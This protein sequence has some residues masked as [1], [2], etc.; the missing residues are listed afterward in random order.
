MSDLPSNRFNPHQKRESSRNTFDRLRDEADA[1]DA[2][3]ASAKEAASD[4]ALLDLQA[5]QKSDNMN[6]SSLAESL[7]VPV[8]KVPK[9]DKNVDMAALLAAT[10]KQMAEKKK[11]LLAA[12]EAEAARAR[13]AE[14]ATAPTPS[15]VAV[16]GQ[17]SQ[18]NDAMDIEQSVLPPPIPSAMPDEEEI[19]EPEGTPFPY[20]DIPVGKVPKE[21][22]AILVP[23]HEDP[24]IFG[25][26][27]T[28]PIGYMIDVNINAGRHG[29]PFLT[30]SIHVATQD[31]GKVSSKETDSYETRTLKWHPAEW[32][33]AGDSMINIMQRDPFTSWHQETHPQS[34]ANSRIQALNRLSD[35]DKAKWWVIGCD[36]NCPVVTD[37]KTW[38]TANKMPQRLR[39]DLA[40][41]QE[42]SLVYIFVSPSAGRWRR[43]VDHTDLL[44]RRVQQDLGI[45]SQYKN[46][47]SGDDL[48]LD[49]LDAPTI[50]QVGDGMHILPGNR[51]NKFAKKTE[52]EHLR[53]F[54]IF[55]ALGPVRDAQAIRSRHLSV[56]TQP[57]ECYVRALPKFSS[58]FKVGKDKQHKDIQEMDDWVLM[59]ARCTDGESIKTIPEPGTKLALEWDTSSKVYNQKHVP[60]IAFVRPPLPLR[61]M[62]VQRHNSEFTTTRTD[63]CMLIR[64]GNLFMPGLSDELKCV[65]VGLRKCRITLDF[66][67]LPFQRE[68][69]AV[70]KF[71]NESSTHAPTLA[72][73][74]LLMNGWR[75]PKAQPVDLRQLDKNPD[76][77][78]I[79][80]EEYNKARQ[81]LNNPSQLAVIEKLTNIESSTLAVQDPAGTG[82]TSVT[83]EI[84][85]VLALLGHKVA[86]LA[87]TDNAVDNLLL[88][89]RKKELSRSEAKVRSMSVRVETTV[90]E[91][92][93]VMQEAFVDDSD[94]DQ[95]LPAPQRAKIE[96]DI[97][98]SMA[99]AALLDESLATKD[100]IKKIMAW[101]KLQIEFS[102]Q[103]DAHRELY[104]Q[105]R[106]AA[107][108]NQ[109]QSHVPFDMKLGGRIRA[110]VIRERL[111]GEAEEAEERRLNP[112]KEDIKSAAERYPV[113]AQYWKFY[114]EFLE[115]GTKM[116]W[117]SQ[118]KFWNLRRQMERRPIVIIV[119]EGGQASVAALCVPLAKFTGWKALILV[120]DPTQ[121]RPTIIAREENEVYENSIMSPLEML[122][123]RRSNLHF[124]DMQYRM[125]PAISY[126]PSVQFYGGRLKNHPLAEVDNNHR[127]LMRASSA[128]YGLPE[129]EYFWMDVRNGE[130]RAEPGGHSL[131][132]HAN[133]DV[134]NDLINKF[135]AARIPANDI[136]ILTMYK[137][138]LRLLLKR[139]PR[140]NKGNLR[141]HEIS[142]IDAFQGRESRII[143][144][145]FVQTKKVIAFVQDQTDQGILPED[146]P[147]NIYGRASS[148]VRD[149]H[150]VNTALTRAQDGLIVVGQ[151]SFF[152]G[153]LTGRTE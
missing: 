83:S 57:L 130:G 51:F 97:R 52:F 88:E 115:Q 109:K 21:R 48:L 45:L 3:E 99:Y 39:S 150:R 91:K 31:T 136:V 86:V 142:T 66:S 44:I 8:P 100:D 26:L 127:H 30:L 55:S 104:E 41:L 138:Q 94:Q 70:H 50:K 62:V 117:A 10:V 105:L 14:A 29:F 12:R 23:L 47:V 42:G 132:N 5:A 36:L 101:E 19:D 90:I 145:D 59:Y 33:S 56:Q 68:L 2:R 140:D 4:Q 11:V 7:S 146:H 80:N 137:A 24:E 27:T 128:S 103:L 133:A 144:L 111:A 120:G 61:G 108:I 110:I 98:V 16:P 49:V 6:M 17:L 118:N 151:Y 119:D 82:K 54:Q 20:G 113:S 112:I 93:M 147:I 135:E 89:Y 114:Q 92:S 60:G 96:Q 71:C 141:F 153:D 22:C 149:S 34:R 78:R 15:G 58:D 65:N 13:A 37:F 121:L 152:M 106:D 74:Q 1:P 69:D 131:Q 139:I 35:E 79:F 67:K 43:F 72:V 123:T 64:K 63:F 25:H 9:F 84:I 28:N 124:L 32:D 73:R 40:E 107:D 46:S 148:F 122:E 38:T 102:K 85:H 116:P 125:A 143:I 126:F 134:I 76:N 18:S 81:R 95:I 87:A 53:T 77:E 75:N 129:S